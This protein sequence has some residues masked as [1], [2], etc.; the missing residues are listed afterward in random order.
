MGVTVECDDLEP[1]ERGAQVE[2]IPGGFLLHNVNSGNVEE[3]FAKEI[4]PKLFL[5]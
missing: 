4:Y 1:A 5:N 3:L 2:E